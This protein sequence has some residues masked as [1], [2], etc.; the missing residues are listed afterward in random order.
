[1]EIQRI[2]LQQLA[3][4]RDLA[5]MPAEGQRAIRAGRSFGVPA[6]KM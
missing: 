3:N 2:Q 6:R 4:T 1:M 5:G